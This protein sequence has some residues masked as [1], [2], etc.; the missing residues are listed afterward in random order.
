M[1][2]TDLLAQCRQLRQDVLEMIHAAGSGHPGGS[3]SAVEILTALYFNV[4]QVDPQNPNDPDRDRFILSKGHAAPILYA[5]LA[6]KGYFDPAILPTLRSLGSP[7]Q[8][9]PHMELLPGL[10]CSSGSLGQGLSIANGLALAARQQ[11]KSYRTYCLMGDG[12][13]QEGQVWEAA[14]TAAHFGLDNVCAIVDNNGVQLDGVT[15]EIM[16]VE[17]LGEKFR[18]FGW[19]VID[20]DGHDLT[21]LLAAFQEAAQTKGKPTAIIAKTVKGKGVSFMENLCAWHGKAPNQ[22]ELAAALAEIL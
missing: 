7:L 6:R 4:M 1:V 21:A 13:V 11:N 19:H 17:P 16:G 12:E 14:M 20:C 22:D 3:L 8:G 15:A 10:D 18:A 2:H 5:V 9:H